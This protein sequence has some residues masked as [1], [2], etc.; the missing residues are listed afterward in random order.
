MRA[1]FKVHTGES[2]AELEALEYLVPTPEPPRLNHLYK[3]IEGQSSNI[4][5]TWWATD[6]E[7]VPQVGW[8]VRP[9]M[10]PVEGTPRGLDVMV[11]RIRL[12]DDH[13]YITCRVVYEERDSHEQRR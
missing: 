12:W 3:C 4:P 11:I 13:L 10:D 6:L 8:Y 7:V 1:I 2:L 9:P 5:M